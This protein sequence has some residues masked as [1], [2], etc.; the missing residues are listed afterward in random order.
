MYDY[1]FRD[2]CLDTLENDY[3]NYDYNSLFKSKLDKE[4]CEKVLNN[5][6]YNKTL[7]KEDYNDFVKEC[8][9]GDWNKMIEDLF[10]DNDEDD[11]LEY[12]SSLPECKVDDIDEALLK[13]LEEDDGLVKDYHESLDDM[14]AYG[15]DP[16]SYYG[17]SESDF[18]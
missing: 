16:Y 6:D 4:T 3:Y 5:F 18:H 17:V 2:Y 12:L 9:E 1:S 7:T 11:V 13:D 15:E 14:D 10:E 8:L